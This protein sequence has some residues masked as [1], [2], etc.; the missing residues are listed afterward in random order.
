MATIGT[1]GVVRGDDMRS[2]HREPRQLGQAI[3]ALSGAQGRDGR[4]GLAFALE[5]RPEKLPGLAGLDQHSNAR[6][7]RPAERAASGTLV[8]VSRR[9][10]SRA[11]DRDPRQLQVVLGQLRSASR[12]ELRACPLRPR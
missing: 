1:V 6:A 7:S 2:L 10:D 9:D 4:L 8:A 5:A 12:L 11:A 3:A